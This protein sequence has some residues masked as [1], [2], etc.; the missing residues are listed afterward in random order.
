MLSGS[1][2]SKNN[3]SNKSQL[4]YRV[5]TKPTFKVQRA[6]I[7]HKLVLTLSCAEQTICL[8]SDTF[9][10]ST[11]SLNSVAQ[12]SAT[13]S[14]AIIYAAAATCSH[15]RQHSISKRNTTQYSFPAIHV[16]TPLNPVHTNKLLRRRLHVSNI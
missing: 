16:H 3:L 8:R 10:T 12:P 11:I 14:A 13:A 9:K 2:D 1:S 6:Q 4:L 5:I 15:V 7:H